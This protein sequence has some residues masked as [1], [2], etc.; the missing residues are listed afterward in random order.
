MNLDRLG[1]NEHTKHQIEK[2]NIERSTVARVIQEHKERYIISAFEKEYE[3]EITGNMRFSAKSRED[4][5]A[6][7]DW[8]VFSPFEKNTAIIRQIIPRKTSLER[9]AVDSDSEKQIIAANI[10][11][12]FIIQGVDR[13]F[14]INRLER[15]ISLIYA[16]SIIPIVILNK[17]DLITKEELQTMLNEVSKRFTDIKII[18]TSNITLEGIDDL[19][20]LLQQNMTYCLIGSSGVG[21]SSIIN[22]L[23]NEDQIKTNT[24]SLA[25]N[26][27]KHTTTKRE[28]ILLQNG[29]ILIDTPGM[30]EIGLT[31]VQKGIKKTFSSIEELSHLCKFNNCTHTDEPGC[32]ILNV[33]ES[34]LIIKK[35][36]DNFKK[37][38]KESEHFN[39]NLADKRKK[40]KEFGKMIKQVLK[41]K[42]NNKY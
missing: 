18:S 24:L 13:D 10:D 34:G 15:Y 3:A 5:P 27:G 20:N 12:A 9:K 35:E 8:V 32:A 36:I 11:T 19:K 23:L 40:D 33:L 14:N 2:L 22:T 42:K 28:L 31:D 17:S 38:V 4:F 29:S 21:K 30:R 1:F 39:R 7:G 6:V 25:S 41:V 16:R 37:L 26:K